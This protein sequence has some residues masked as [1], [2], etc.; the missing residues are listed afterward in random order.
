MP[1]DDRP[2]ADIAPVAP[3]NAAAGPR[4]G[5]LDALETSYDAQMRNNSLDGLAYYFAKAD[6]EQA[7]K[8]RKAGADYKPLFEQPVPGM[9]DENGQFLPYYSRWTAYKDIARQLVDGAEVPISDAVRT[10]NQHIAKLNEADPS[11]QLQSL[12]DMFESVRKASRDAEQRANLSH[13]FMGS[14]GSFVGDAAAGVDPRTN[15]LNFLTLPVGGV[16]KSV[17]G[18][19]ATQAGG[20]AITEAVNQFTG[21]QENRRLLGLEQQ[22]PLWA[23]GG[24]A[25]GGAAIQGAGEAVAAG[26][27]RWVKPRWFVDS[28][29]DPAPPEPTP[30]APV[31]TAAPEAPAF[32]QAWTRTRETPL[33][34][35]RI[36]EPRAAADLDHAAN[37]LRDWGGPR[38]WEIPPPTET[39]LPTS[40]PRADAFKLS[41]DTGTESL[42]SIARRIDPELFAVYDKLASAKIEARRAVGETVFNTSVDASKTTA[43]LNAEIR[44]LQSRIEDGAT[45]RLTKKYNS[46]I[47]KLTADVNAKYE[48]AKAS[49]V[50]E[51]WQQR[52][53]L[54]HIDENMRDMAPA[55]GRAYGLAQKKWDVYQGQKAQ[56]DEMLRNAEPGIDH[57][58]SDTSVPKLPEQMLPPDKGI[59]MVPELQAPGAVKPGEALSDAVLRQHTE[60]TAQVDEAVKAFSSD[61]VRLAKTD[62]ETE[63]KLM[64]R[65]KELSL[66]MDNDKVTLPTEDGGTRIVS[67]RQLAKELEDDNNMLQAITSCSLSATL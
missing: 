33:A 13:S 66:H 26:V 53:A 23:I 42:D 36:G 47:E 8:A 15:I 44:Q 34:R 64:V 14:V 62:G 45:P 21:V 28:P 5:F 3:Y 6:D 43:D 61:I 1:W 2:N 9:T 27:R 29:H 54:M 46:R 41:A 49:A 24:A 55:V 63:L 22:N 4:L 57:R 39:R 60:N 11:L 67:V 40:E 65:G 7:Q 30:K 19:I 38:A 12:N 58:L 18:R 20:Q 10:Q 37:A 48:E 35:S 59:A 16:G 52:Q 51:T 17:V 25:L 50:P 32:D 56:I 31:E